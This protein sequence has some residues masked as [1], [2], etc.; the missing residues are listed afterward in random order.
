MP[1]SKGEGLG[2]I[3]I[4]LLPAMVHPYRGCYQ[5]PEVRFLLS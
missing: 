5:P 1:L 2:G 3:P 4:H